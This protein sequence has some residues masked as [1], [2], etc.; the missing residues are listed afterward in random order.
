MTQIFGE[1]DTV[2]NPIIFTP[3]FWK[4][5][6]NSMSGFMIIYI[7]FIFLKF[8]YN[9]Y[10]L[11]INQRQ[12]IL[13]YFL[14]QY[15]VLMCIKPHKYDMNLVFSFANAFIIYKISEKYYLGPNKK[16][17]QNSNI[18]DIFFSKEFK[19][20]YHLRQAFSQN[21]IYTICLWIW[22]Y[23]HTVYEFYTAGSQGRDSWADEAE[24]SGSNISISHILTNSYANS[25]GD[26]IGGFI[27]CLFVIVTLKKYG[28]FWALPLSYWSSI[29][30]GPAC[31]EIYRDMGWTID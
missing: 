23:S 10:P 31:I 24:S 4:H 28:I 16:C 21:S 14:I 30:T 3:W 2:S 7:C 8:I 6:S 11:K 9:R 18:L 1:I 19:G 22:F 17:F 25:V 26:T 12:Y 15:S 5:M 13:F 20:K 29:Y 27:G